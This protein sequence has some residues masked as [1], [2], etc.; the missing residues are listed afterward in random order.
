M[1]DIRQMPKDNFRLAL[2]FLMLGV[3]GGLALDLCAKWLLVDYSL[4]Q[5][6]FLRSGFGVIFFLLSSRWYG[7]L[8]SLQTKRWGWHLLRTFLATGAMFGFFYGLTLMPL[9]NAL[10]I[11]FTAPLIV[12]AMSVPFLGEHVGWRRWLAVLA[13][14]IGVVIV[15]RPGEGMFTPAS[16]AV[17]FAALCWA[18]LSVTARK[19][20]TTESSFSLSLYIT[21]GPLVV[22]TLLLP[23]NYAAPTTQAWILFIIAGLCSALAWVGIVGG[24]RRAPPVVLAPFEYTALIGAA[25][26]GYLI[27]DEVPD[28]WVVTGATII[29]ASGIYIVFREIGGSI[30][31]RYLRVFTAG[32]AAE[33]FKRRKKQSASK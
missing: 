11:A 26:A 5:F 28:R 33:I 17:L 22:S 9:V 20:A 29:I 14:F 30:T 4:E 31:N 25:V 8:G 21:A 10:T 7:G 27:W 24:Y 1:T 3:A 13:G 6:V 15:L 23:G 2:S 18:G 16:V 32:G 19:L 12:T